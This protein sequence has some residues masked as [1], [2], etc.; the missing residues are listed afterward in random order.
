MKTIKSRQINKLPISLAAVEPPLAA[1]ASMVAAKLARIRTIVM[2]RRNQRSDVW[3]ELRVV[4]NM[5]LPL[6]PATLCMLY[7]P[8]LDD[9]RK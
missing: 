2:A 3:G 1:S 8:C 6:M 5:D 9:E 4:I 7:L